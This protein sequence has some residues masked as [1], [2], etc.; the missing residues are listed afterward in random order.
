MAMISLSNVDG[1]SPI[2]CQESRIGMCDAIRMLRKENVDWTTIVEPNHHVLPIA[3]VISEGGDIQ[4]TKAENLSYTFS[5]LY[6]TTNNTLFPFIECVKEKEESVDCVVCFRDLNDCDR[7]ATES[8][9][10]WLSYDGI[11]P[12]WV[13]CYVVRGC[14]VSLVGNSRKICKGRCLGVGS[15]V[16]LWGYVEKEAGDISWPPVPEIK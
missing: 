3:D 11:E 2:R 5:V 8:S 10:I 7:R 13:V 14:Q 1:R 12:G 15:E 4:N 6:D 9:R 16:D